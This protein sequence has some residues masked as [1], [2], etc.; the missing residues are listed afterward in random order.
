MIAEER[1]LSDPAENLAANGRYWRT[2]HAY[3]RWVKQTYPDQWSELFHE[4]CCNVEYIS[5][6]SAIPLHEELVPEY[7]N[8]R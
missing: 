3:E 6:P 1:K 8:S 2:L 5:M 4:P 7:L